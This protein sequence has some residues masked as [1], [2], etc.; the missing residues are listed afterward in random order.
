MRALEP[1]T[2]FLLRGSALLIGLLTLWW[3]VLL[4]P[5][6]Y[7]LKGAA[8]AFVSIEYTS[9]GDWSFHVPLHAI[10]PATPEHPV[11]R[12]IRSID[13]DLSRSDAIAFTFSL[14]VYWAII[15]A[16]PDV[17]RSLSP[18]LL[19]TILVSAIEV[20][21]LLVFAEFTARDAVS[22]FGGIADAEGTW[23]RRVGEYLIV[24][25]LPYIGPFVVAMSTHGKLRAQVFGILPPT[26][27]SLLSA[28]EEQPR[29]KMRRT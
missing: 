21:L 3:F 13:F 28:R 12:E 8:G 19:G 26:E 9:S 4:D 14:P 22:Q 11:A 29:A 17:K 20:A 1:Q 6:L 16:A 24:N 10:L 15:L 27:S 23:L 2:R 7:V 25:V 5:M 18:L